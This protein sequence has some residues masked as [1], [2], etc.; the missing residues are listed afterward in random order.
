MAKNINSKSKSSNINVYGYSLDDQSAIPH[1]LMESN[2]ENTKKGYKLYNFKRPDKF[3]K[4]HLRVLQDIHREFARQLTLILT[5]YLRMHVEINVVSIDQLTYEEFTN[6][7]PD[8]VTVGIVELAPLPSQAL[9]Y[10]NHEVV[11]SIID[12]M[13]GGTGESEIRLRELTDIEESLVTKLL[14]RMLQ[15]LKEAWSK[16]IPIEGHII[17]IDNNLSYSQVANASEIAALITFEVQLASKYF[18]LFSICFPYPVLENLLDKLSSQ[19]IFQGRGVQATE[20]ETN[21]L[22]ERLNITD[23]DVRVELGTTEIT[24][25]DFMELKNG[26]VIKL[27]N[28]VSDNLLVKINGERKFY[29]TPGMRKN[30]ISVEITDVYIPEE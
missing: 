22:I 19:H 20:A 21:N 10:L 12:R 7:M 11:T 8:T 4:D 23:V 26:D 5:A 1:S 6:S 3:S 13:F 29:A 15:A 16:I 18:G 9:I 27:D 2:F 17:N 25:K 30:K 14:E 28:T 24:M